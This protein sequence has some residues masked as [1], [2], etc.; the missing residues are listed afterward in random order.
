MMFGKMLISRSP[1][2]A[3]VYAPL[4]FKSLRYSAGTEQQFGES[5]EFIFMYFSI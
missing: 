4:P 2:F 3:P 5:T 1:C